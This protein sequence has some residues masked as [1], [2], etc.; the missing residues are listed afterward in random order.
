MIWCYFL[1]G[2]C[3]TSCEESA[4]K[5]FC[6]N[7]ECLGGHTPP[8]KASFPFDCVQ[9]MESAELFEPPM[10]KP[11]NFAT[12]ILGQLIKRPTENVIKEMVSSN[13]CLFPQR[14]GK[15]LFYLLPIS[16]ILIATW[17]FF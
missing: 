12:Y 3:V 11:N 8:Y 5:Q 14:V 7:T 10:M 17:S 15:Y 2:F 9:I 1:F 13:I 6:S 16:V 4:A